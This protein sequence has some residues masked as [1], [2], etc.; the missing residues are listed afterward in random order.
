LII[1]SITPS[2]A[3]V[4]EL[5]A[6]VHLTLLDGGE[7]H[8]HHAE[9]G[10]VAGAHGLLHVVAELVLDGHRSG[11]GRE[12]GGSVQA[13]APGLL[14]LHALRVTLHGCG[15]LALAFLGRLLVKLTATKL[16][17]DAGLL[18]GPL[19]APQG[20]VKIFVF[21]YAYTRH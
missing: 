3:G 19:E 17:Q 6:L 20:G 13:L 8:A 5:D 12:G 7:R 18:T 21:A 16:G 14:T 10:L 1:F 11:P 9:A 4:V 2:H 15:L